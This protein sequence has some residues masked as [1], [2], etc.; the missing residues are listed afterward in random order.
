VRL[1]HTTLLRAT[2]TPTRAVWFRAPSYLNT[3][4]AL[5][6]LQYNNLQAYS[7]KLFPCQIAVIP[8]LSEIWEYVD[9]EHCQ[10]LPC[11]FVISPIQ[12]V[13]IS[14]TSHDSRSVLSQNMFR[15][16]CTP[17]VKRF[18]IA[19][20]FGNLSHGNIMS[21]RQHYCQQTLQGVNCCLVVLVIDLTF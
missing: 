15:C 7:C 5:Q 8:Q 2:R 13:L 16:L 14:D 18:R 19:I 21:T 3:L 11:Q 20:C 1:I 6:G 17:D 4:L 12:G 10:S 9:C